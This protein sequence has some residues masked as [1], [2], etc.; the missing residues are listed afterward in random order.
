MKRILYITAI[1]IVLVVGVVFS[2]RN[3]G[4]ISLDFILFVVE[5]NLSLALIIALII[6]AGLGIF[7]SFFFLLS[8][9]R[10]IAQLKKQTEL[11]NKELNNLRALPIRDKH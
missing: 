4:V 5:T 10:N 11:L 2:A 6:G 1:I 3:A 9:K 7:V 8:A